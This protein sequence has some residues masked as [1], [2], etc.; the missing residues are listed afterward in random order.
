VRVR[1][2]KLRDRAAAVVPQLERAPDA[3]ARL[4]RADVRVLRERVQIYV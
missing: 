4:G 3:G 1:G 2:A